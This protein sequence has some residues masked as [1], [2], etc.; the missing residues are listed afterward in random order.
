MDRRFLIL[1]IFVLGSLALLLG[2][3]QWGAELGIELGPQGYVLDTGAE[4]RVLG[5]NKET[6]EYGDRVVAMA[7]RPVNSLA[8]VGVVL[9][10]LDAE[11]VTTDGDNPVAEPVQ[12]PLTL[13][14][15][16]YR[17][18]EVLTL[19]DFEE[20]GL[21]TSVEKEDRVFAYDGRRV[22]GEI[23]EDAI[24]SV[25]ARAGGPVDFVFERPVHRYQV[26][27]PLEEPRLPVWPVALFVVALAV[28]GWAGRASGRAREQGEGPPVFVFAVAAVCLP[29]ALTLLADPAGAL[30]DPFVLLPGILALALYRPLALEVHRRL[31]GGKSLT[32][33]A[34]VLLPAVV[35]GVLGLGLGL[36]LLAPTFGGAVAP[37]AEA[38]VI[39]I[40]RATAGLIAA[41][42]VVDLV[43]WFSRGRTGDMP[44]L[45][46]PQLGLLISTLAVLT[47]LLFWVRDPTSFVQG[48]F[49]LHAAGH[50]L[51]IFLG[52]LALLA[53]P[54]MQ[55]DVV[56][57]PRAMALA[58][59]RVRARRFMENLG[60]V[61]HPDEPVVVVVRGRI[62]VGLD[63]SGAVRPVKDVVRDAVG[64]FRDEGIS[65]PVPVFDGEEPSEG[66]ELARGVAGSV[67]LT[68]AFLLADEGASAGNH[69]EREA[70]FY[71]YCVVEAGEVLVDGPTRHALIQ[72]F[73]AAWPAIRAVAM[74]T[75]LAAPS[76]HAAPPAERA[77]APALERAP[78]E[79]AFLRRDLARE[80]PVE[81]PELVGPEL[82]AGLIALA[83]DD[84]PLIVVGPPGAGKEFLARAFHAAS[85]SGAFIKFP[86]SSTPPSLLTIELLGDGEEEDDEV[87]GGHLHAARGGVLYIEDAGDLP[88]ELL[89]Q[90]LRA[91][92][93][94][95]AGTRLVFGIR[96]PQDVRLEGTLGKLS[97]GVLAQRVV[98][99]PQLGPDK[100]RLRALADHYILRYAM[101][102]GAYVAEAAE[103]VHTMLASRPWAGGV[104][105]LKCVLEA[106][107]LRC[108]GSKLILED[109]LDP[110]GDKPAATPNG[111]AAAEP[112]EGV[113]NAADLKA[114]LWSAQRAAYD[115]ALRRAEGNKSAAARL[116]GVKRSTFAKRLKDTG[117][118]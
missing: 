100:K 69:Q 96:G 39:D 91:L 74:D 89:A 79:L 36:R 10:S 93:G 41:Y 90:L 18:T 106:A 101:K 20:R 114:W 58:E 60:G 17:F 31:R 95:A 37:G 104:R 50:I 113:E 88:E 54:A 57:M 4:L 29:W 116:V 83:K 28:V 110:L 44:G 34:L 84:A 45:R 53:I 24:A 71:A 56:E 62:A 49:V 77:E 12:V 40:I 94:W 19:R 105:E 99:I 5:N 111:G 43:L 61:L 92:G 86:V 82:E 30:A 25:L 26:K 38:Q 7:G 47:S 6:I 46:W 112:S 55:T 67:G 22:Q 118:G 51:V 3:S 117:E 85:R 75:M 33:G 13:E 64:V 81:D 21:P 52:D 32:A 63:G 14:R 102:H 9:R 11:L 1:G 97:E 107:V 115:E 65:F 8:E 72:Q 66:V 68:T 23:D 108:T 76:A 109:F 15:Y 70:A 80:Y 48:G 73:D 59:A 78:L 2:R 103:E 87:R 16:R 27:L 35:L 42:H 98:R